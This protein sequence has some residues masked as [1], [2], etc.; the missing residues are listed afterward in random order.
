MHTILISLIFYFVKKRVFKALILLQVPSL[1]IDMGACAVSEGRFSCPPNK[2]FGI[3]G[4]HQLGS[5]R[6]LQSGSLSP[7][8]PSLTLVD[9]RAVFIIEVGLFRT[10]LVPRWCVLLLWRSSAL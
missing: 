6:P 3:R 2:K 1:Q 4:D 5:R 8:L 7:E 9:K 10:C